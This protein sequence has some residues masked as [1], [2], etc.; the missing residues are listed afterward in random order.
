MNPKH[1][2]ETKND[3]F[4]QD[5][6]NPIEIRFGLNKV[7]EITNHYLIFKFLLYEVDIFDT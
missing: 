3:D 5:I 6:I 2:I 1:P 7:Y 4:S